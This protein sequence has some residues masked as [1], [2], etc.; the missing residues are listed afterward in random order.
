VNNLV[1]TC[2]AFKPNHQRSLTRLNISRLQVLYRTCTHS[3]DRENQPPL[4]VDN[5]NTYGNFQ[6]GCRL[7]FERTSIP[8]NPKYPRKKKPQTHVSPPVN[9]LEVKPPAPIL[10]FFFFFFFFSFSYGTPKTAD[11]NYSPC[12]NHA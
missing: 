2:G 12:W 10:F 6:L 8:G 3:Q 4:L 1:P 9:R 11:R 7:H 5:L